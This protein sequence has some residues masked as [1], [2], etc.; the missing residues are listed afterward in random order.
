MK[1]KN[2][3]SINQFIESKLQE[4]YPLGL[5]NKEIELLSQR[6]G[7]NIDIIYKIMM[8]LDG[9]EI[10]PI[11]LL[12]RA[13]IIYCIEHEC[14]ATPSDF[15]IRR[16]GALYFDIELVKKWKA[17]IM[18]YMQKQLGWSDELFQ[19]FDKELQHSIHETV[20]T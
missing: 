6:Y 13:Q 19:R 14:C 5:S 12:L 16:T 8:V 7:A 18:T 15:F 10:S 20:L 11:P 9:A 1:I 3:N 17:D 4:G 2:F